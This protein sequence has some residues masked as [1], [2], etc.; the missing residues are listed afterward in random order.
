MEHHKILKLLNDSTISKILAR[1]RIEVS[2]LLSDQHSKNKNIR[3]TTPILWSNLCE[4]NNDYIV[5]LLAATANVNDKKQKGVASKK[6]ALFMLCIKDDIEIVCQ[7]IM[8]YLR[9]K[10][11]LF[12]GIRKCMELL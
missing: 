9:V 1:K 4:C 6:N 2:D 12:S 10:R 5:D 11:G 7:C 8:C 3:L